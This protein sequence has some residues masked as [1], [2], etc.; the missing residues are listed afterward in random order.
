MCVC[1]RVCVGGAIIPIIPYPF[2]SLPGLQV[3]DEDY[4]SP[5]IPRKRARAAD[6]ADNVDEE[7]Y[8]LCISYVFPSISFDSWYSTPPG[9]AGRRRPPPL[10]KNK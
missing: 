2:A 9:N 10:E 3:N 6:S 4:L 5:Q 7:M 8:F 1:V